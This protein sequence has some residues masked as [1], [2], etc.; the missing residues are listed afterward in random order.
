MTYYKSVVLACDGEGC[1]NMTDDHSF[2]TAT[3]AREE[4]A[5]DGW[6]YRDG[7]DFCPD[8]K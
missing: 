8:C 3:R 1:Y 4:A 6:V 7:Q 5:K 2:P